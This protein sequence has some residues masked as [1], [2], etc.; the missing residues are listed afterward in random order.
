MIHLTIKL[1]T[2]KIINTQMENGETMRLQAG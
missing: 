2:E 1:I